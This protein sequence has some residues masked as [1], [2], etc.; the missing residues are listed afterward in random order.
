MTFL[1]GSV[2]KC[3]NYLETLP[4]TQER[5]YFEKNKELKE[6]SLS[7]EHFCLHFLHWH[8]WCATVGSAPK[9]QEP[10]IHATCSLAGAGT[11]WRREGLFPG[12]KFFHLF[13]G[14]FIL[15]EISIMIEWGEIS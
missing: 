13:Y 10:T 7:G 15:T 12:K 2:G 11:A 6:V 8:L 3:G 9:Q 14:G 4:G 5:K 1:A